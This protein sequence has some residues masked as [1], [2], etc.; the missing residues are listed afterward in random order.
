MSSILKYSAAM[1]FAFVLIAIGVLY[2]NHIKEDGKLATDS[3]KSQSIKES[4]EQYNISFSFN[5]DRSQIIDLIKGNAE[6][7]LVYSG[8]SEFTAKLLNVDGSLLVNLADR[9]GPF[10]EKIIAVIPETGAYLLDVKTIGEWSLNK[11]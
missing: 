9:Y 2:Y 7:K 6:L 10:S 1:L 11:E 4:S 8:T 5:G 3:I